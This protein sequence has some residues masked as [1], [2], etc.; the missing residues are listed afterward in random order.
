MRPKSC[1]EICRAP[2]TRDECFDRATFRA[3]ALYPGDRF[4]FDGVT[5][6][7]AC[8]YISRLHQVEAIRD[9]HTLRWMD[10]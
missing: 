5:E 10:E 8:R 1:A 4:H 9:F 7:W 2:D 6:N 3:S